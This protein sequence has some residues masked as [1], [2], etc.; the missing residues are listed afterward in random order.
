M[1]DDE[2]LIHNERRKLRATFL[3]GI[4]IAVFAI[5]GLAPALSA[6]YGNMGNAPTLLLMAISAICFL[7]AIALHYLGSLVLGGLRS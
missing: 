4:A 5:G 7:A 2:K 6:L 1:T 3:N